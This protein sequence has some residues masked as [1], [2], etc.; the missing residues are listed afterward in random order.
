VFYSLSNNRESF[1]H[2]FR[3]VFFHVDAF[4]NKTECVV[5]VAVPPSL[6]KETANIPGR[7]TESRHDQIPKKRN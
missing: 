7:W 1:V 5:I 4:K 3:F 6:P 2:S